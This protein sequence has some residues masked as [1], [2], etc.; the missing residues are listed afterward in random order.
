[1]QIKTSGLIDGYYTSPE[2]NLPIPGDIKQAAALY[3]SW[4]AGFSDEPLAD[5]RDFVLNREQMN[6]TRG[7]VTI[8][9]VRVQKSINCDGF[10]LVIKCVIDATPNVFT[11]NSSLTD[12]G[13][14]GQR[15]VRVRRSPRTAVWVDGFE[16]MNDTRTVTR[17]VLASINGTIE[18][19]EITPLIFDGGDV[20]N[21]NI[22]AVM[23]RVD[24]NLEAGHISRG[25][26]DASVTTVTALDGPLNVS[27]RALH[28]TKAPNSSRLNNLAAWFGAAPAVFGTVVYGATPMFETKATRNKNMTARGLPSSWTD[29]WPSLKPGVDQAGDVWDEKL[30]HRFLNVTSGALGIVLTS[31]GTGTRNEG[32]VTVRTQVWASRMDPLWTYLLLL[33]VAVIVPVRAVLILLHVSSYRDSDIPEPMATAMGDIIMNSRTLNIQALADLGQSA[34]L[35][36]MQKMTVRFE[37]E[38]LRN[39]S[40]GE[41]LQPTR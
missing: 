11:V 36:E 9:A 33:P 31:Y 26:L 41:D 13:T 40:S 35:E 15:W 38:G 19:G 39:I 10:P 20:T 37:N 5:L 1:M 32:T 21:V 3:A 23:C 25:P 4:D 18:N 6:A 29:S 14:P 17:L 27:S 34:R 2:N 12:K 30:I 16:Y 24:V 22:S 28:V 8:A 7:N